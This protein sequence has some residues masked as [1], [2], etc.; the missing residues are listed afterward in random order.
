M[1]DMWNHPD[2]VKE[3]TKSGE[4]R[5]K[6]RFS[7]D[8][9]KKPYLSR[10]EVRVWIEVSNMF[11]HFCSTFILADMLTARMDLYH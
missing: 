11:V 7:H 10:G 5:G 9:A 6:V 1:E 2:V 3:W 4:K 8:A